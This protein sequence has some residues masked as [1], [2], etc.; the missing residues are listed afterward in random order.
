MAG[1]DLGSL[2][3]G[4]LGG[5]NSGS[6]GGGAGNI[7]GSLLGALG[8]GGK[9]GSNPLGGLME[10]LQKSGLGDQ[11]QSWIGT[12][13]N[14]AVS[15]EQVAKALPD[16]ALAQAAAQA[17][18]TQQEAA[19]TLAQALPQAVDKLTPEGQLPQAASLEDLIKQQGL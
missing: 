8:G 14:Q 13:D 19:D 16:E 5:G 9:D 18:V 11:A 17:G 2:L 7:L 6:G 10:M 12:G 4:L 1:N 15:G 3:G